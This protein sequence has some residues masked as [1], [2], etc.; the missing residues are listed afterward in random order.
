VSNALTL[1]VQWAEGGEGKGEKGAG[2]DA[3]IQYLDG[4]SDR[5][6]G[7]VLCCAVLSCPALCYATL[8]YTMLCCA[9]LFCSFLFYIV[10]H[11]TVLRYATICCTVL[12][13]TVLCYAALHCT[14]RC[15][16]VLTVLSSEGVKHGSHTTC[17]NTS[18]TPS[19]TYH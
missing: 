18:A 7:D 12:Y 14:V 6:L 17:I 1:C 15:Y 9:A 16:A 11:C 19:S 10:P 13:C 8:Y 2:A 5:E 4:Q 3:T